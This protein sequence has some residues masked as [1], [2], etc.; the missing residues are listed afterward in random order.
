MALGYASINN[1]NNKEEIY[2]YDGWSDGL[3]LS[4]KLYILNTINLSW[5]EGPDS[6]WVNQGIQLKNRTYH[7]AVLILNT[8]FQPYK[9][10]VPKLLAPNSQPSSLYGHS[11]DI[12]GNYMIIAFDFQPERNIVTKTVTTISAASTTNIV[13]TTV[14]SIITVVPEPS[15]PPEKYFITKGWEIADDS[16]MRPC[17]ADRW[18][19]CFEDGKEN[20][21]DQSL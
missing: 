9:W 8:G 17:E 2:I 4:N 15:E 13:T 19:T 18:D 6:L 3:G 11:A 1:K 10:S 16:I 12:V 14:I 5:I 7:S 20:W 21:E